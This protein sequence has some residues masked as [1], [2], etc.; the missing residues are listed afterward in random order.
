[1]KHI[2]ILLIS[3]LIIFGIGFIMLI[4]PKTDNFLQKPKVLEFRSID[5]MKYSRDIAREKLNDSSFDEII[6]RQVKQ[7]A[8]TGATHVAIG[9][10]Y[11]EEFIPFLKRWVVAARK[12][13]LKVWFRGNWSG[14]EGWFGYAKVDRLTHIQK[15]ELF[16]LEHPDLFKDGD[17]FTACPEC[18]NGNA[19][20]PRKNGD[21]N[22]HRKFLIYEYE[23]TKNA[24]QKIDKDVK[25]NYNSMNGDIAR[26][27]MDRDTTKSLDGIVVIDHYVASSDQLATDIR[28]L[29]AQSGGKIILGE[30]GAPIPDI[31]GKLTENEQ[32]ELLQE[33]FQ[34]LANVEELVGV[35]YWT[36]VG[37]TTALWSHD[38]KPKKAVKVLSS[39][40]KDK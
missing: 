25:S 8:E 18:E 1:M 10:P 28:L 17:V 29:A 27:V 16:I 11:D 34:K 19:G 4:Q 5:T 30:Y 20:D 23:K 38:G 40:F 21:V 12:Y 26:L 39:F 14:W 3:L 2:T 33:T 37:G 15:T 7:I 36:S 31:H 9:T 24:F 32:A 13:N 22:G 6:D 35:N